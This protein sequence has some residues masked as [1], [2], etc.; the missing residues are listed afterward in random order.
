M[1]GFRNSNPIVLYTKQPLICLVFAFNV[2]DWSYAFFVKFNSILNEILEQ[3]PHLGLICID[4]IWDAVKGNLGMI[5]LD[6]RM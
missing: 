6:K 4:P 2:N 3:S 5:F 1:K